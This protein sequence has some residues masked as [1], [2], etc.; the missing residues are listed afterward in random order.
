M[1]KNIYILQLLRKILVLKIR[2]LM[3]RTDLFFYRLS[4]A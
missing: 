4:K 3:A 2:S 1:K